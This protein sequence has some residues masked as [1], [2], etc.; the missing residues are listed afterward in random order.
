[1][2]FKLGKFLGVCALEVLFATGLCLHHWLDNAVSVLLMG[3][4]WTGLMASLGHI[5]CS[6]EHA[7]GLGRGYF[8][9]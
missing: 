9:V 8:P 5:S 6:F 2:K 7:S 1:M 4:I 3:G